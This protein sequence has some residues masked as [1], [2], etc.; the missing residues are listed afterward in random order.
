MKGFESTSEDF[1]KA[2][3]QV[4]ILC[5]ECQ[6]LNVILGAST[7][8]LC[9]WMHTKAGAITASWTAS[10]QRRC[11]RSR[12]IAAGAPLSDS[13]TSAK[14]IVVIGAG[15]GG[16][17]LAGRLAKGGFSVTVLERN[18]QARPTHVVRCSTQCNDC[19]N[20]HPDVWMIQHA[21]VLV[22]RLEAGQQVS[23]LEVAGLTPGHPCCCSPTHTERW[24]QEC[25]LVFCGVAARLSVCTS[26]YKGAVR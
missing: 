10:P 2:H 12:C 14:K 8:P 3:H 7:C 26:S 1:C 16:I 17:C 15:I 25:S 24:L 9:H 18:D 19:P 5:V 4:L 23:H 21:A 20:C 6:I 13:H 22:C 11:S